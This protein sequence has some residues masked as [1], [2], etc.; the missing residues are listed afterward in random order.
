M[1]KVLLEIT[2]SFSS[3]PT[4]KKDASDMNRHYRKISMAN[5][6]M[7]R[8]RTTLTDSET[9]IKT[10]GTFYTYL[11]DNSEEVC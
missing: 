8:C 7:R 3:S 6:D 10:R 2:K 11:R 1:Y 5:K 4:D 9:Q